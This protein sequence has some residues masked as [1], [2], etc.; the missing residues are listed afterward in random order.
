MLN[1]LMVSACNGLMTNDTAIKQL[2][3]RSLISQ[4]RCICYYQ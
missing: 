2:K 3:V 4:A 1:S